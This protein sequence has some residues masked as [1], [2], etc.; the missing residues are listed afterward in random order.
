MCSLP[1]LSH[2]ISTGASIGRLLAIRF[3]T[4]GHLMSLALS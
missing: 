2:H 1:L 4:T 3:M